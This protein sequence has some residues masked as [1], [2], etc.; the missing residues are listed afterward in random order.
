M[1]TAAFVLQKPRHALQ[2]YRSL[3]KRLDKVVDLGSLGSNDPSQFYGLMVAMF[4]R[5][6]VENKNVSWGTI[7]LACAAKWM[8][9][10]RM[11]LPSMS[12]AP[13]YVE[14]LVSVLRLCLESVVFKSY[15]RSGGI[16]E[17]VEHL[18]SES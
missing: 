7:R 15:C 18:S 6:E 2:L 8:S 10:S 9:R 14:T 16:S 17:A 13:V 5:I 4:S 3:E 12:I 11:S 1:A